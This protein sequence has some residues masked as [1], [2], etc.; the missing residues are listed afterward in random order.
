MVFSRNLANTIPFFG[1]YMKKNLMPLLDS[2]F[3]TVLWGANICG[4][5]TNEDLAKKTQNPVADFMSVPFH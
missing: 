3:L 1:V 5:E 4:A 2:V